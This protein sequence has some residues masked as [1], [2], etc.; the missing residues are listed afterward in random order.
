M[1]K[2]DIKTRRGKITN[3]SYGKHRKRHSGTRKYIAPIKVETPV[4]KVEE[5]EA[6]KK[7][8]AKKT[9]TKAKAGTKKPVSKKTTAVKKTPA[10]K[11]TTKK[12]AVK[13]TTAKKATDNE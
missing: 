11:T 8:T 10:K 7:V 1:G 13:K 5:I 3:G 12:A 4:D 2:G 6:P 9:T